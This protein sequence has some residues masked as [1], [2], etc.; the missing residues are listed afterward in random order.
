MLSYCIS[1]RV[2]VPWPVDHEEP[3][4]ESWKIMD[5][6]ICHHLQLAHVL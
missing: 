4:A 6:V 3:E 1:A 2:W 5:M